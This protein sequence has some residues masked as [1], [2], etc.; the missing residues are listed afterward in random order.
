MFDI[1]QFVGD[2]QAARNETEPRRAIREVLTRVEE[3]P[4]DMDEVNH[5][6]AEANRAWA[7]SS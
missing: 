1:D 4:Y 3:R 7:A 6:F 2:C 5:Q